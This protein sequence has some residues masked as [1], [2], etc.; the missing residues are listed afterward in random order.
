MGLIALRGNC[1]LVLCGQR[2]Q[3][4]LPKSQ[5]KATEKPG[6]QDYYNCL[7]LRSEPGVE[8]SWGL[9]KAGVQEK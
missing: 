5:K 7:T 3:K 2:A 8:V 6:K 1:S 4:N 9:C